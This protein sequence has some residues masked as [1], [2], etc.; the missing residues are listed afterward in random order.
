MKYKNLYLGHGKYMLK[1]MNGL[2]ASLLN[3]RQIKVVF[4]TLTP[5]IQYRSLV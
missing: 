2:L 5:I 1:E 4:P 3:A